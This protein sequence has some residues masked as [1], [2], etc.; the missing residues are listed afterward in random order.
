LNFIA[1]IILG[2]LTV[3][4]VVLLWRVEDGRD[5]ERFFGGRPVPFAA[6]LGF[7][8]ATWITVNTIMA[9]PEVTYRLG[10]LGALAYSAIGAFGLLGFGWFF[11]RV[12]SR[13]PEIRSMGDFTRTRFGPPFHPLLLLGAGVYALGALIAPGLA[14]GILV[15]RLLG[16]PYAVSAVVLYGM[17]CLLFMRGGF[18]MVL[19]SAVF[20]VTAILLAVLVM[21]LIVYLNVSIPAVYIGVMERAP[22]TLALSQGEG[23]LFLFT[24]L[25]MALGEVMI[26]NSYWQQASA[27]TAA[28]ARRAFG[29][30]G[31]GWAF[32][33]FA[34]SMLAFVALAMMPELDAVTVAPQVIETYVGVWGL[35]L[36]LGCIWLA[37]MSSIGAIISGLVTLVLREWEGLQGKPI[38]NG[39]RIYRAR[40]IALGVVLPLLLITM[41]RPVSLIDV[42]IWLGVINAAFLG[43]FL[44]GA[45][46]CR[47]TSKGASVV[48]SLSLAS[49][50]GTYFYY[51]PFT[52]VILSGVLSLVLC[53]LLEWMPITR[54]QRLDSAQEP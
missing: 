40:W 7:V 49:G 28:K 16:V 29:L 41:M 38:A 24:G 4:P 15:E 13:W 36:L 46:G 44:I 23:W 32:V 1:L 53:G 34:M 31:I 10:L 18:M 37:A 3:W 22:Q 52:G 9:A 6:G 35:W 45:L 8:L 42:L 50:Y 26:D 47:L 48:V 17:G 54:R 30:A 19:R 43:P 5:A 11:G 2:L 27:L 12:M 14:G 51:S 20:Q 33:P 39:Q 21:P 25:F